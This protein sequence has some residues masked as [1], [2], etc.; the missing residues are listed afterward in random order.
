MFG[1][2]MQLQFNEGGTVIEPQ[3]CEV[4]F[5]VLDVGT[6]TAPFRG[7]RSMFVCCDISWTSGV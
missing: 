7:L 2:I 3:N 1:K 4:R 6:G 5:E